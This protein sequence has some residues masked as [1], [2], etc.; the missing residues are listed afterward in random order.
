MKDLLLIDF[1]WLYNKYYFV[2]K[3][4][5]KYYF[6]DEYKKSTKLNKELD[7]V[8]FRMLKQFL[9]LIG[10]NYKESKVLLVLDSPTSSLKNFEL[11]KEYK[12]NRNKEEKKEVYSVFKEIVGTLSKK[13]SNK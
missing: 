10:T 8:V 2:A 1:S 3:Y 6:L 4:K 12:Q 7:L 5:S 13:L 11:Y 9:S